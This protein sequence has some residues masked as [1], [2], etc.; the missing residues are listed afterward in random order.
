MYA[1]QDTQPAVLVEAAEHRRVETG[2]HHEDGLG[3]VVLQVSLDQAPTQ[4]SPPQPRRIRKPE[5]AFLDL[6]EA[7]R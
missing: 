1:D 3:I 6:Q 5:D 4:T 2:L 7:P